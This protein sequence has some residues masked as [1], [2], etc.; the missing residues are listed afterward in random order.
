MASTSALSRY[1]PPGEG[2]YLPY[3]LLFLSTLAI[4]HSVVCYVS[5]PETSLRQYSVPARPPPSGLCARLYGMKNVYTS[6]I[7][8]YAAY[9]I[10]NPQLYALAM[11]SFLGVVFLNGTELVVYRTARPKECA[12][13]LIAPTTALLWM[14][15][16]RHYYIGV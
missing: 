6:L 16:Q 11:A 1:L 8:A 13:A 12:V 3:F 7:R 14:S 2:G 5:D 10:S 9:N 15:S 4:A